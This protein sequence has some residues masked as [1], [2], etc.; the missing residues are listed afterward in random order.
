MEID[1]MPSSAGSPPKNGPIISCLKKCLRSLRKICVSFFVAPDLGEYFIGDRDDYPDGAFTEDITRLGKSQRSNE[2]PG[3]IESILAQDRRGKTL[4]HISGAMADNIPACLLW[5]EAYTQGT[6]ESWRILEDSYENRQTRQHVDKTF[7]TKRESGTKKR[8]NVVAMLN[9]EFS[10]LP[11]SRHVV[12]SCWWG[13]HNDPSDRTTGTPITM[14]LQPWNGTWYN[15]SS[16]MVG[17]V[18]EIS[19]AISPEQQAWLLETQIR[20]RLSE[21]GD[22]RTDLPFNVTGDTF[23][24]TNDGQQ[25]RSTVLRVKTT[26]ENLHDAKAIFGKIFTCAG[27]PGQKGR[28]K[29]EKKLEILDGEHVSFVPGSSRQVRALAH[30]KQRRRDKRT[31]LEHSTAIAKLIITVN[32]DDVSL[33]YHQSRELICARGSPTRVRFMH[34]RE[35][36]RGI[37]RGERKLLVSFKDANAA[38]AVMTSFDV[39]PKGLTNTQDLTIVGFSA[40]EILQITRATQTVQDF[41][42]NSALSENFSAIGDD[43]NGTEQNSGLSAAFYIHLGTIDDEELADRALNHWEDTW[44][45]VNTNDWADA[46][47]DTATIKTLEAIYDT[48]SQQYN[49]S[50]ASSATVVPQQTKPPFQ[51]TA[52]QPMDQRNYDELNAKMESLTSEVSQLSITNSQL[53]AT[54]AAQTYQ[55]NAALAQVTDNIQRIYL[56]MGKLYDVVAESTSSIETT[57]LSFDNRLSTVEKST[58]VSTRGGQKRAA[59]GD[60]GPKPFRELAVTA[61]L[62]NYLQPQPAPPQA[63]QVP[64]QHPPTPPAQA[65]G[66]GAI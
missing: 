59:T 60:P 53:N 39:A 20:T 29:K 4:I 58:K 18:T 40:A 19:S 66:D 3:E 61:D 37:R 2:S 15:Q 47:F 17:F 63:P 5:L 57:L 26:V 48:V 34:S 44:Y 52:N 12:Q 35:F 43:T 56:G 30:T 22:D 50:I 46:D 8:C 51:P 25:K 6:I 42:A 54:I 7:Y 1:T 10:V 31:K 23:T 27:K 62:P 21:M 65:A 9:K 64:R 45:G 55:N 16:R 32:S 11:Y 24:V 33:N 49:A 36:K 41:S 14:G 28:M 13:L 38:E